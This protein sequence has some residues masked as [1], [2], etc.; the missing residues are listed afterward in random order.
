MEGAPLLRREGNATGGA[1]V[2][3]RLGRKTLSDITNTVRPVKSSI[4]CNQENPKAMPCSSSKEFMDLMKE[5]SALLKILGEK[6]KTIQL[7]SIEL[8]KLRFALQ[9]ANQQNWQLAQ[10]NSQMLTELNLAKDRLKTLQHELGCTTAILRLKTLE[11]EE[12]EKLG[13]QL[14]EKIASEGHPKVAEVV[15]DACCPAS[16]KQTCKPNRKRALET[17]SLATMTD[18]AITLG[19]DDRRSLRR[20]YNTLKSESCETEEFPMVED[21]NVPVCLAITEPL[22]K[23]RRKPLRLRSSKF[24]SELCESTEDS[25]KIEDTKIPA[26]SFISEELHEDFFQQI[27][28]ST[29]SCSNVC[30]KGADE[31]GKDFRRF[32][33]LGDQEFR[34]T[35]VGR[36]LRRAAEK[37]ISYK[38]LPLNVKMR[39]VD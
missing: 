3:A 31:E 13:Q 15:A 5:N 27:E 16:N 4:E 14:C 8:Q 23:D 30:S 29:Y 19:K 21:N 28:N 38:E 24:K 35:S 12:K 32:S 36:P 20:R 17:Q 22:D 10:A 11:M 2:N 26:C 34:R 33:E 1:I 9:K 7:S 37:V 25:S 6:N 39:R 18:Q